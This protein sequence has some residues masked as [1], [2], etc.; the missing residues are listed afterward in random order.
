MIT[1]TN[2]KV[3]S[4]KLKE[5]L[6]E[7][8]AP[9]V[10]YHYTDFS[11]LIKILNSGDLLAV[12][13]DIDTSDL[14]GC[15]KKRRELCVIR[16]SMV[17]TIKLDDVSDN[18]RGVRFNLKVDRMRDLLR[19]L[20][21]RPF[22]ELPIGSINYLKEMLKKSI[23]KANDKKILSLANVLVKNINSLKVKKRKVVDF[24]NRYFER[25]VVY[26]NIAKKEIV[27]I[28]DDV[29]KTLKYMSEYFRKREGEERI[30]VKKGNIPLDPKYMSIELVNKNPKEDFEYIM[31]SGE[32][33]YSDKEK[34]LALKTLK[35]W[36]HMFI[37]NKYYL[38]FFNK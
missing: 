38:N 35:K 15:S 37:K 36:K 21:V 34:E 9:R 10:L 29:K 13:H 27:K 22:A 14:I 25:D 3:K 7:S 28:A 26:D 16:P 17:K 1:F 2:W 19:N 33:T 6:I 12:S 32:K 31:H 23:V 30:V 24:I 18:M 5:L 20:K 4:M 8:G 11:S